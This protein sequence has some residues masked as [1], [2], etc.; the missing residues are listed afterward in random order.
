MEHPKGLSVGV[1]QQGFR[2]GLEL[3]KGSWKVDGKKNYKY[4]IYTSVYAAFNYL[5]LT[6]AEENCSPVMRRTIK[7][8]GINF[9]S[10]MAKSDIVFDDD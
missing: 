1:S 8:R 4:H 10:M 9:F 3:P 2:G 5:R 7:S 6:D